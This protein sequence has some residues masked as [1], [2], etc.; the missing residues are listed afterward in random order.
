MGAQAHGHT[1]RGCWD[2][3]PLPSSSENT[4]GG[5]HRPPCHGKKA[6]APTWPRRGEHANARKASLPREP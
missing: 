6:P 3:S 2:R 5:S 4:A 1:V